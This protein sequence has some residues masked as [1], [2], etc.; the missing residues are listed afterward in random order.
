MLDALEMLESEHTDIRALLLKVEKA[1]DIRA[2]HLLQDL[3]DRLEL[4]ERLEETYLY[5]P[6]RQDEDARDIV[7]EGFEE[8]AVVDRLIQELS[9]LKPNDQAWHPKVKVLKENLERH[10][11]EEE[12]VL[13]PRVRMIWDT[14]KRRHL[15]RK[16]EQ[17]KAQIRKDRELGLL[18]T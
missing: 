12:S 3:K 10:I 18:P 8:H 9:E 11:D 16:M 15:Y 2:R 17:L 13:F 5:S 7:L 1:K 6:L 4:V 14:D